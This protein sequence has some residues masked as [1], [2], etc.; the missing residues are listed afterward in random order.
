[1][2]DNAKRELET[3]K[4]LHVFLCHASGDKPAVRELYRRL[5]A[6]GIDAWLDEE[7]LLPGQN[8]QHEIP[9]AVHTSDV[10]IVCLSRNSINKAGYI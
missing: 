5:C 10:V 1:M 7:K 6:E 8:W 2:P 9:K 3:P 4:V